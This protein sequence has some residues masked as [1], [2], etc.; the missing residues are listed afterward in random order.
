MKTEDY[1]NDILN[2]NESYKD[3]CEK[4]IETIR[5]MKQE[6]I[7]LKCDMLKKDKKISKLEGDLLNNNTKTK[8][9]LEK[10]KNILGKL[11]TE[12]KDLQKKYNEIVCENSELKRIFEYIENTC[13]SD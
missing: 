2:E 13:D 3:M 6:F 8:K 11:K 7:K 4:H 10:V 1:I 12:H 5:F 9:E